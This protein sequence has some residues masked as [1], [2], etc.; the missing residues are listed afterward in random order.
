MLIETRIN[1]ETVMELHADFVVPTIENVRRYL[2]DED[3]GVEVWIDEEPAEQLLA[4][5][6]AEAKHP[7]ATGDDNTV[8]RDVLAEM[9]RSRR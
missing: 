5:L 8:M 2:S 4:R 6:E 9:G 1:G 3:P 7:S